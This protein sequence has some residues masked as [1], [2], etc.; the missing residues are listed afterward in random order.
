VT[1]YSTHLKA[2]EEPVL[3]PERFAWGALFFGPVW[4]A[5]YRAWIPAILSFVAGLLIV[6]LTDGIAQVVLMTGLAL[7]L[8]LTGHDLRRWSLERSGYLLVHVLCGR[9]EIEAMR[10]LLHHRPDLEDRYQPR[11]V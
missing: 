4:L 8:G 9:N 6:L 1:F 5:G 7:I 3:V 11:P 10:H 2:H